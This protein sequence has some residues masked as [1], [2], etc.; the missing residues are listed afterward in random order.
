VSNQFSDGDIWNYAIDNN[1]TIITKD[2]DFYYRYL[3]SSKSPK[4]SGSGP[5]I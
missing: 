3:S 2:V 4:L 5:E 1:L